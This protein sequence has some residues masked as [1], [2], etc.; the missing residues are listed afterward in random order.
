MLASVT[1]ATRP[2]G[3]TADRASAAQ[4]E[5]VEARR[6]LDANEISM[7]EHRKVIKR[8]DVVRQD[9][10]RSRIARA[11]GA[12]AGFGERLVQFWAD[13]FTVVPENPMQHIMAGAFVDEAIRPYIGGRFGD[14]LVAASTHPMMVIYLNQNMSYGPN[15]NYAKKQ[16]GK[17]LGL[18]ENLGREILELHTL[19]V[20]AK[21]TQGDV[22]ELAELLT[23]L[24]YNGKKR[25]FFQPQI[26]EPG[27]ETV[28]G[29]K[30]G[31]PGTDGPK[32]IA[33][34]L[35]D[36]AVHPSTAK[37]IARKL[38]VHFVAD[39]PPKDLI[40]DIAATWRASG[41]DLAQVNA[42]LAGH[43]ELTKNFRAK[44]R[45]P[46]DLI[47]TGFRAL[48]IGAD[49]VRSMDEKETNR[50]LF[51]QLA[52]MG[53]PFHRARGPDGWPELASNW[54]NPQTLAARIAWGLRMPSQFVDPLPD[55]RQF[56]ST[57][58]GSTVSEALARAVPRAESAREGIAL[59]LASTDFNRR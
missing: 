7:D 13:H 42:I 4:Q 18:N 35:N 34:A 27:A 3:F 30:Y 26:A 1:E 47:A 24:T 23:G 58:L 49:R 17:N 33:R 6:A 44:A 29:R 36:L 41:G 40:E 46:F 2:D 32:E 51:S 43:P 19:G 8:M 11:V 14:M 52:M 22:R 38:A 15:S 10:L 54:I 48:G 25:I 12:P 56:L 59:V 55:P 45:Q 20:G 21:Y 28:L 37:H 5:L 53:Q 31:G 9:I 57:A 50:M 39:H 16:R